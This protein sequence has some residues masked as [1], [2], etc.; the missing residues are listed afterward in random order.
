[1]NK[2]ISVDKKL[3]IQLENASSNVPFKFFKQQLKNALNF[4][5]DT[6]FELKVCGGEM[7]SME[8]IMQSADMRDAGEYVCLCTNTNKDKKP[9]V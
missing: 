7:K 9:S 6:E 2:I 3:A 1:M 5:S 8:V 4:S